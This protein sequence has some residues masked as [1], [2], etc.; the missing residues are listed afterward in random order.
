MKNIRNCRKEEN[1]RA[2]RKCNIIGKNSLRKQDKYEHKKIRE[3][4]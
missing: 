3:D 1:Y 4:R 2:I